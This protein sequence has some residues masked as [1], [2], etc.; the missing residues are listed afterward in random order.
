DDEMK[1]LEKV[2]VSIGYTS[3]SDV[4]V[5]SILALI[6]RGEDIEVIMDELL[7]N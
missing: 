1:V 4:D 2:A 5:E 3:L 6:I 7:L